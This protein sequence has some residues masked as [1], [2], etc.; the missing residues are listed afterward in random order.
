MAPE[1]VKIGKIKVGG[2]NK[3]EIKKPEANALPFEQRITPFFFR[4]KALLP[5]IGVNY[6]KF[7]A[8]SKYSAI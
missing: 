8:L 1:P 5:A 4:E 3:A 2:V 6:F 7:P